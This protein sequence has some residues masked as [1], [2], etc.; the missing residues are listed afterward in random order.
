MIDVLKQQLKPSMDTA[1]KI[2]RV[3]EF[4]QILCL[5]IIHDKGYFENMAFVGG[6]ALRILYDLRRFSEDLDFSVIKKEKYDFLKII[7]TLASELELYGFDV[8]SKNNAE[9]TVQSSF[10]KFNNLLNEL[11]LSQMKE[12]KLSIRIEVD[13]NPPEGWNTQ[14]TLINKTYIFNVAHFDLPSLYATKLHACFFR[15]FIKGR[16]FYDLLWYL[17]RKFQ[18]NFILLNNAVKQTEGKDLKL[19]EKNFKDFLSERLEKVNF[20]LVKK[21]VER[22]LEDKKELELLDLELIRKSLE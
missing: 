1:E 4:L 14:T 12:Q 5:K 7:T 21:D 22:F 17:G 8:E 16:D 20:V 19:D 3:R 6:T 13:S 9:K 10:L 11:G 18:P 15:K 2:N